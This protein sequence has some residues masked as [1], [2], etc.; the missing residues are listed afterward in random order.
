MELS[1][2]LK[3]TLE[4]LKNA[5]EMIGARI[6]Q[7]SKTSQEIV[8]EIHETAENLVNS[9]RKHEEIL[10]SKAIDFSQII[11]REFEGKKEDIEM[12]IEEIDTLLSYSEKMESWITETTEDAILDDKQ[13][14][15][16]AIV[17]KMMNLCTINDDLITPNSQFIEFQRLLEEPGLVDVFCH[18][19]D[20]ITSCLYEINEEK[21]KD[22]QC[23]DL[24][25]F[26]ENANV[27]KQSQQSSYEET[28][29]S[30]EAIPYL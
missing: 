24:I 11:L 6:L 4:S 18:F 25:D 1:E 28:D 15:Q 5:H 17:S 21:G 13:D 12:Q 9:I 3:K 16:K 2:T 14:W 19:G 22:P 27:F 8:R 30:Y 20:I 23:C 7:T 10:V 26:D 29:S